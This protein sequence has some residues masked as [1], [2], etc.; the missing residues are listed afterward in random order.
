VLMSGLKIDENL[1]KWNELSELEW[2]SLLLGNGFSINVW[3]RFGYGT[4]FEVAQRDDIGNQLNA[5]SLAL[6]DHVGSSNFEDVLRILYHAKLVDEQLGG[7]QEGAILALYEGV[8]NA[9]ASAVN[10]AHIPPSLAKVA[11]I[12]V[13][14]RSYKNIFTTNY[15]LIPY[16]AIMESDTWR[17]K[18]YF[19]GEGGCF[20]SSDTSV[21]ADRT[22]LHYLH[23]A[24]H[25]VELPDG[26]TK[27][28]TANGLNRL[29]ELFDLNHPEQFP[30]FVTEGS[31]KWKLSRIK[32]N[33]YLRFCYEK[34][35]RSDNGL[36]II[37]HSL[38]KD[39]DQHIID[40]ILESG[41]G[42][43]AIGVW[44]HQDP[45]QVIALKSR[46]TVDLKEKE[47][48]FFDSETHPLGSHDLN[49]PDEDDA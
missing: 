47:L 15:D 24:I 30:L 44:P 17:F 2:K 36:V 26:R 27:K 7:P 3:H 41:S 42:K 40:A 21:P 14:F 39:Y 9:L 32:R 38:R 22:K 31:S 48:Y 37:G 18:D 23:G 11:E 43:V 35:A 28:L 10:F 29:S 33:D 5:Q 6:F 45:E 4:L 12:N 16:W 20:D 19:W 46:L 34:L 49:V 8:K 25:L 13:G 1:V